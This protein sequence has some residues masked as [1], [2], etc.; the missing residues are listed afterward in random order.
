VNID[1]D[2]SQAAGAGSAIHRGIGQANRRRRHSASGRTD[3]GVVIGGGLLAGTVGLAAALSSAHSPQGT[4][5]ANS[6]HLAHH[7]VAA[8]GDNVDEGLAHLS[9]PPDWAV[10]AGASCPLPPTTTQTTSTLLVGVEP[11]YTKQCGLKLGH[12]VTLA[13]LLPST[14]KGVGTPRIINGFKAYAVSDGQAHGYVVPQLQTELVWEGPQPT[15]L[16]A[17]ISYSPLHAFLTEGAISATPKTWKHYGYDEVEVAAP[18]AW[19][20]HSPLQLTCTYA[21]DKGPVVGLGVHVNPVPCVLFLPSTTPTDGVLVTKNAQISSCPIHAWLT[22]GG[23]RMLACSDPLT[24]PLQ[25][26]IQVPIPGGGR[27]YVTIAIGNDATIARTILGSVR[28]FL[29]PSS[30]LPVPGA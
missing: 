3:I 24:E 29:P 10:Q 17:S 14:A 4:R 5:S 18:P 13:W 11:R 21:F 26:Q 6:Q 9:L 15:R 7:G 27:T 25:V 2:L 8:Y 23:A 30:V 20:A 1:L 28:A 12:G 19:P 22:V 16:V